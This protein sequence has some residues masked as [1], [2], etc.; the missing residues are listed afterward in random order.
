MD[1]LMTHVRTSRSVLTKCGVFT[2][3]LHL[4][5]KIWALSPKTPL[6]GSRTQQLLMVDFRFQ[7]FKFKAHKNQFSLLY[8]LRNNLS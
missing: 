2:S 8:S 7:V 6:G 4:L 3:D 1:N 5:T